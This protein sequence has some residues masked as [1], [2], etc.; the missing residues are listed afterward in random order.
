M[1]QI[2]EKLTDELISV[3]DAISEMAVGSKEHQTAVSTATTL[4]SAINEIDATSHENLDRQERRR[5]DEEKNC[6]LSD[7][8]MAKTKMTW[9]KFLSESGKILLQTMPTALLWA[10]TYMLCQD[11]MFEF[12]KEGR[13]L[14]DASRQLPLAR[15][16][17]K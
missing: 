5:I 8:E 1:E 6:R 15:L 4:V 7:I 3:L 14:S 16:L 11:R 2:R 12:E 9:S 17:F 13:L 10:N